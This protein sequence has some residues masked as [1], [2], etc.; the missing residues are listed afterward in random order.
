LKDVFKVHITGFKSRGVCVGN[1]AGDNAQTLAMH[2]K[3]RSGGAEK[4]I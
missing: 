2:P 4:R 3:G 1:I